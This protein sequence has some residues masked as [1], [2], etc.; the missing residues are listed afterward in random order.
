MRIL[1]C[2]VM[3]S[4]YAYAY[5]ITGAVGSFRHGVQYLVTYCPEQLW[6]IHDFS[7]KRLFEFLCRLAHSWSQ[8]TEKTHMHAI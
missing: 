3:L 5:D 1:G 8:K 2:D 4:S 7:V 6:L